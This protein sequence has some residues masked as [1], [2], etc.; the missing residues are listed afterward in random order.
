MESS[1][2]NFSTQ[3]ANSSTLDQVTSE[4]TLN[5]SPQKQIDE[6]IENQF[7]IVDPLK[8]VGISQEEEEKQRQSKD[9]DLDDEQNRFVKLEMCCN[10]QNYFDL[11]D[12]PRNKFDVD[13]LNLKRKYNSL[14]D[15]A[16]DQFSTEQIERGYL[17]L[18]D[19][20]QRAIYILQ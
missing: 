17:A 15:S 13:I 4:V 19:E 18:F 10:D 1:S 20:L 12:L 5:S 11:F 2:H 3:N 6:S 9:M 7:V 16:I 8:T 14:K